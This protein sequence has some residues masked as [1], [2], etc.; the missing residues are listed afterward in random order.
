[1]SCLPNLISHPINHLI[2]CLKFALSIL[3]QRRDP[4]AALQ[5]GWKEG[6][7]YLLAAETALTR[8]DGGV[9]T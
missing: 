3:E 5:F 9:H 8:W 2:V 4:N 6:R 1:M 7:F